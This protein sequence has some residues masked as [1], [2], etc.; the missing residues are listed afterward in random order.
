MDEYPRNEKGTIDVEQLQ[1]PL[2][3]PDGLDDEMAARV[4]TA[5][6]QEAVTDLDLGIP[7]AYRAWG[8]RWRGYMDTLRQRPEELMSA[9]S[10]LLARETGP[11]N[12]VWMARGLGLDL[13][14]TR[15]ALLDRME[16][17]E[18]RARLIRDHMLPMVERIE[19]LRQE[20]TRDRQFPGRAPRYTRT[21]GAGL[22]PARARPRV[23]YPKVVDR[24]PKPGMILA[25]P[26]RG[27]PG[28]A[29][30]AARATAR[31]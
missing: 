3:D 15:D 17:A 13:R 19:A 8:K 24:R 28:D 9:V 26:G 23:R 4:A 27:T 29:G 7:S 20:R 25:S 22:F 11:S 21:W 2:T 30:P 6:I 31:S 12:F 16:A 14:H 18:N 10:F 1:L 5:V